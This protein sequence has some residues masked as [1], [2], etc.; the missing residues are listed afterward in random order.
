MLERYFY[1]K[2]DK[3]ERCSYRFSCREIDVES[4][5]RIFAGS[6]LKTVM[7]TK[8]EKRPLTRIF[9]KLERCIEAKKHDC[10]SLPE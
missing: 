9:E 1:L 2:I 8:M 5:R 4:K 10:F 7:L 3:Q 6:M